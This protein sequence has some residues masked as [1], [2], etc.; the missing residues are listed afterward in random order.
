[1]IDLLGRLRKAPLVDPFSG[2]A[3]LSGR[4]AGVTTAAVLWGPFGREHL[5]PASPNHWLERPED[6]LVVLGIR[7]P[8]DQGIRVP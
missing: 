8:G 2:P 3:V 4:A 1:M 7:G 6:L 5:A